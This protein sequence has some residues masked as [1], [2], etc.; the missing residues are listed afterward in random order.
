VFTHDL[1]DAHIASR[2]LQL[3]CSKD[4][5]LSPP[6][7]RQQVVLIWQTTSSQTIT[8][9]YVNYTYLCKLLLDRRSIWSRPRAF[10]PKHRAKKRCRHGTQDWNTQNNVV[11]ALVTKLLITLQS[12]NCNAIPMAVTSKTSYESSYVFFFVYYQFSYV[13]VALPIIYARMNDLQSVNKLDMQEW[14]TCKV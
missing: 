7:P 2:N 11:I 13:F 5:L 8:P 6:S 1:D 14:T 12:R 3:S 9:L 4:G 10:D